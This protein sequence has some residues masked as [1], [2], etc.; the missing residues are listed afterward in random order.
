MALVREDAPEHDD[1]VGFLESGLKDRI[2]RLGHAAD[3][4]A[5]ALFEEEPREL[6]LHRVGAS[7]HDSNREESDLS[8]SVPDS[9][10]ATVSDQPA[11]DDSDQCTRRE[12]CHNCN[13]NEHVL[14]LTRP[15]SRSLVAHHASI[16]RDKEALPVLDPSSG[17]GATLNQRLRPHP[18]P[19][20]PC[21]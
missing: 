20:P 11:E 15:A 8:P 10:F 21:S 13:P 17:R 18:I 16:S 12:P 6:P 2:G 7:D 1:G 4:S 14:R 5:S 19:F 3:D 9:P